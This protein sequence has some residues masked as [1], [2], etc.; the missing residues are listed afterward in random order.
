MSELN[1]SCPECGANIEIAEQLAAPMVAA[2]R[3]KIASAAKATIQKELDKERAAAKEALAE[4]NAKLKEAAERELAAIKAKE[5]AEEAQANTELEIKRQVEAEKAKIVAEASSKATEELTAKLKAAEEENERQVEKVRKA[6]QAELDA[7]KAKREAEEAK[8]EADIIVARKLDKERGKLREKTLKEA[9]EANRLKV[10]EKDKQ[11]GDLREQIEV[12]K[13]KGDSG[14]QQLQGEVQEIDL[15][16]VL[17][18]AFPDD[19]FERVAKGQ[20]G[21]DVVQSIVGPGGL[22]CGTILWESKRTN[23][24]QKAWLP[25]LREDQRANKANVAALV[26]A[27][28]PESVEHF[29]CVDGVWVSSRSAAIP[30]AMALRQGLVET[31]MARQ[32]M[33]G[34]NSK[35]ERVYNYLTGQEFRQRVSGIAESYIQMREDLDKEKRAITLQWSKREKHLDRLLGNTVGMYGDL[36]GIIGANLPEVE[37]LH[38]PQL[39]DASQRP[40]LRAIGN[41]GITVVDDTEDDA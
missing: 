10:A 6:Q 36:Q 4:K 23:N 41:D 24:W 21:A 3:E 27:E 12:L 20:R 11:L 33:I 30:M 19:T 17:Q 37:G 28:L 1:V 13:R 2:E 8:E 32:A 5:E 38:L 7:I 18:K 22:K 14:S 39:E 40:L 35:K 26:S 34:G 31:A 15:A 16:E 29:D 9:D 25:K